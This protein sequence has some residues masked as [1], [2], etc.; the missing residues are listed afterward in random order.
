MNLHEVFNAGRPFSYYPKLVT[1]FGINVNAVV[2]LCRIGWKAYE[3][4]PT[5]WMQLSQEWLQNETGL[6]MREQRT[7]RAT[8]IERGLIEE[9]YERLEH[10]L[11]IR[12]RLPD[13]DAEPCSPEITKRNQPC[14]ETSFRE[15][16]NVI[17][18][19]T[20][21]TSIKQIAG[22]EPTPSVKKTPKHALN[23]E[24]AAFVLRWSGTYV[25]ER[26]KP[27]ALSRE[28][29]AEAL[30]LNVRRQGVTDD[31]LVRVAAKAWQNIGV[32]FTKCSGSS[33]LI[34]FLER[35]M[36]IRDEVEPDGGVKRKLRDDEYTGEIAV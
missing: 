26:G 1:E 22:N 4:D 14:D 32:K 27:F 36:A 17:S 33:D 5:A 19:N 13:G 18:S 29:T 6:T 11:Y 3:N 12:L 9:K 15:G 34:W 16:R 7:A 30:Y 8:L 35:Y 23:N 24:F 28:K 20:V 25:Q 2:L 31:E 10:K 21:K